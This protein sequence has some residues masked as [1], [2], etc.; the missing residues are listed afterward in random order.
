MIRTRS[1]L[2]FIFIAGLIL[3]AAAPLRPQ[4]GLPPAPASESLAERIAFAAYRHGQWDIYS[5]RPDGSD[6]RQITN[7]RAEDTDPAFSPDGTHLAFAS[8]RQN[9][10][11]IYLLNL[12]TGQESRLTHS[13]H[14]DG[15]PAWSPDGHA[16]AYESYQSGN[17]DIW[18]I[19]VQPGSGRRPA[20]NLTQNAEAGDFAPAFHPD[21]QSLTFSSWRGGSQDLY[22]LNLADGG[23]QQLTN[24]LSAELQPV[25]SP[26]GR[27][28]AYVQNALGTREVFSLDP[29]LPPTAD[30]PAAQITWLGRTSS[31]AFSPDGQTLAALFERWDG[32]LL[33]LQD[34]AGRQRVP[35]PLGEVMQG[36]GRLSW[37]RA[38][39]F[40]QP[41]A[42][43]ADTEPSPLYQ[44]RLKPNEPGMEPYNLIR[45]DDLDVGKPWL[46]DPVDDSF[47]AWRL[48]LRQEVGY[49]FLGRLSDAARDVTT[50][51]DTSQYASWHK[52]GR[53]IDTLFDE[54]LEGWVPAVEIV[55]EDYSGETFWRMYLRC[56]DQSGRCGRPLTFN[57]WNYS[58]QART[59]LAPEEGGT[60]KAI[61]AGY[62]VDLT[63]VA[64][65]YGWERISSYD[66]VD[67]SWTWHFLAFEYW[68]YQKRAE[69]D[70]S[71]RSLSWYEAMSQVYPP[72][73]LTANFTWDKMRSLNEDPHLIALKGVPM[74][75]EVRPWW[76]LVKQGAE[77]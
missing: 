77:E 27:Q 54:Y 2:L 30:G 13:P 75:P 8:R 61:P 48:R 33:V 14:Y 58:F 70:A 68:H 1:K 18:Q 69:N 15:A 64:R 72:E 26:D 71:K 11:D 65:E 53:A 57:P 45:Q 66:D 6:L 43:L 44:E 41:A 47:Q 32:T 5:L 10:W 4:T 34:A 55:R 50:Y 21:G 3:L 74:P 24:S 51:S 46:A 36:Q 25:W 40:G 76:S 12:E 73:V 60:E 52:S 39:P 59:A 28:L 29:A 62:Y 9:N 56:E 20:V 7:D 22:R 19:A 67:Y 23:L 37:R 16:L 42:H 63:A 38:L 17:L 31:P 35:V 49:D